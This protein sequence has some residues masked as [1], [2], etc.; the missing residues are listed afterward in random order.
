MH[1]NSTTNGLGLSGISAREELGLEM[2]Q[3]KLGWLVS[4][5]ARPKIEG[6]VHKC[7]LIVR[8]S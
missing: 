3:H 7:V 1:C 2:M 4:E 5:R 6:H 8:P